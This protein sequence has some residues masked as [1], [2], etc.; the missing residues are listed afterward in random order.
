M[1]KEREKILEAKLQRSE[2]KNQGNECAEEVPRSPEHWPEGA[3]L[4]GTQQVS[5]VAWAPGLPPNKASHVS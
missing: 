3:W 4:S 2:K 5:A 1:I